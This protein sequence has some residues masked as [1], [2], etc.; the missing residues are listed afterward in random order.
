MPNVE[1]PNAMKRDDLRGV[2]NN[3]FQDQGFDSTVVELQVCLIAEHH[4]TWER[5]PPTCRPANHLA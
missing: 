2:C 4:S 1:A 3:T 5:E